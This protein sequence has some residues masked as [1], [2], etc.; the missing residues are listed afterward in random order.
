MVLEGIGRDTCS[1]RKDFR[2]G[3]IGVDVR[4]DKF[5]GERSGDGDGSVGVGGL[6]VCLRGPGDTA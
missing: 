6:G 4:R 5:S 1:G 3:E 2:G